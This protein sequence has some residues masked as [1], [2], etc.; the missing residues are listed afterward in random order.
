MITTSRAD[1]GIY[2]PA[3]AAMAA[4]PD[5]EPR[6]FV[7]GSHTMPAFGETIRE[8]EAS[9][10]PIAAVIPM[11]HREGP[12]GVA[13]MMAETLAGFGAAFGR[14]RPDIALAL[15][16]RF[17]MLAAVM[18]ASPH[19]LPVAHLHGGEESEGAIDNMYRHAIAKLSHL[20][21]CATALSARRL[22]AMGEEDWR[23]HTVGA[24]ALD[25][26]AEEPAIARADLL[27]RAG[28]PDGP[29]L[30]CTYHPET[31]RGDATLADFEA[32]LGAVLDAGMPA[33]F[34][35][36]N[37]DLHGLAMNARLA[38][39]AAGTARV[40]VVESLGRSGYFSAMRHAA[41]MVGNSS[42]GIIEAASFALPVVNVGDRQ[43]GRERSANT[44]DVPADRRAIREAI[45]AAL[46]GGRPEPGAIR[47]VYG[48][49][50]ASPKISEALARIEIGPALLR[51]RFT[52][53]R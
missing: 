1:F 47:N 16:D 39:V 21:F 10:F 27:A 44:F 45:G 9:G 13:A 18:A 20:H 43:A 15:G 5:L 4:H 12:E 33:L 42:S 46:A 24:P 34:T 11:T 30:L 28:L 22:A 48:D 8:I 52:L 2:R 26:V 19:L 29:F 49:G 3:L 7:G 14:E 32:V 51:K 37:P 53:V 35:K 38:E 36:A 17:E 41:A 50:A 6:L 31:L 25:G 23:I 40:A